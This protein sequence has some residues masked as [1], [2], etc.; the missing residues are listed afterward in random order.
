MTQSWNN[1]VSAIFFIYIASTIYTCIGFEALLYLQ[2]GRTKL[3]TVR[4]FR[5]LTWFFSISALA[6][7]ILIEKNIGA[8]LDAESFRNLYLLYVILIIIYLFSRYFKKQAYASAI[9]S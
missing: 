8:N 4:I 2:R 1:V 9:E 3:Q 7:P 6:A 5:A